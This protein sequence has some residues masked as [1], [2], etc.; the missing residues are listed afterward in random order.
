[1]PGSDQVGAR[2]LT[3]SEIEQNH[4]DAATSMYV[5][6]GDCVYDVT[7]FA[8]NHP[9]GMHFITCRAGKNITV[10]FEANHT[11]SGLT[12]ALD[13]LEDLFVGRLASASTVP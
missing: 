7:T 13:V 1:M 4:S 5:I 10:E 9:G 6:I 2:M 8:K 3:K 12:R 11:G